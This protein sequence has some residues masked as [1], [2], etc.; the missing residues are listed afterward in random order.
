[1]C[2]S[3]V[4]SHRTLTGAVC[5]TVLLAWGSRSLPEWEGNP[6]QY[7][8]RNGGSIRLNVPSRHTVLSLEMAMVSKCSHF[9]PI[10]CLL[11]VCPSWTSHFFPPWLEKVSVSPQLRF[12]YSFWNNQ[13]ALS[14]PENCSPAVPLFPELLWG[15]WSNRKP[16]AFPLPQTPVPHLSL[17]WWSR[18]VHSP[19]GSPAFQQSIIPQQPMPTALYPGTVGFSHPP[20]SSM[21]LFH[22][23]A[24]STKAD[25]VLNP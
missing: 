6:S 4:C 18:V 13:G 7:G 16:L 11:Y 5:S 24:N 23:K 8:Q 10:S 17:L 9:S 21:F 15:F 19:K 1:M 3:R 2:S 25:L 22:M 14:L 12:S 20:S